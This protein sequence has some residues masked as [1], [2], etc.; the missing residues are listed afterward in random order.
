MNNSTTYSRTMFGL[1][2]INADV[3]N[4]GTLTATTIQAPTFKTNLV[5]SINSGN[6]LTLES[7]GASEVYIRSNG[8][9]IASF[10]TSNNLITLNARVTQLRSDNSVTYGPNCCLAPTHSCKLSG[11]TVVVW[12]PGKGVSLFNVSPSAFISTLQFII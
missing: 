7:L 3:V 10:D 6:D 8:T 11:K 2:E 1:T 9:N 4:T 12:N 5:Q